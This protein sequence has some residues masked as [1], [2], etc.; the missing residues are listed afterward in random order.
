MQQVAWW[1]SIFFIIIV[2]L[3][4]VFIA[5]NSRKRE[6]NFAPIRQKGNKIRRV[7]IVV[8]SIILLSGIGI[9][10]SLLP[11]GKPQAAQGEL[12]NVDVTAQQFA[13]NLSTST[14]VAGKTVAFHVTSKDVNHGFGVYDENGRLLAQTQAMPGYV[15]TVYY[16]FTKPGKYKI[17]CL[18]YCGLAHHY[19]QG[20]F[21]V[22]PENQ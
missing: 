22:V 18:E 17:L 15:N 21:E 11:Y 6:D 14:I 5:V 8:L 3:V 1:V 7:W 2:F 4:F 20:E 13:F 12:Q 19:M 16:T 10:L 9:A